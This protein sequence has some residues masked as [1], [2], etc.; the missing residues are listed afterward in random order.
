MHRRPP[1]ATPPFPAFDLPVSRPGRTGHSRPRRVALLALAAAFA[2]FSTPAATKPAIPRAAKTSA[3]AP[4]FPADGPPAGW[5]V[6]SWNDVSFP[7][8]PNALWNVSEGVLKGSVPRG[9][10]L[11]SPREYTDFVLEFEFRLGERGQGGVGLRFPMRG[12]PAVEGLEVQMVDPRFYGT[13]YTGRPW[14]YTGALY[15]AVAPTTDAYKPLEWN[16]YTIQCRGNQVTVTLNGKKVIDVDLSKPTE[17][18]VPGKPLA[19]RPARGRIGFQEVSRGTA[20]V[21]I[22][23]ARIREWSNPAEAP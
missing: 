13:N 2:A 11:V 21:E 4:L 14:E 1:A 6:R 22:R 9:T 17:E 7:A 20:Q 23:N 10:W 5:L 18:A 8:Q 19:E 15:K 3:F 16:R 12:D